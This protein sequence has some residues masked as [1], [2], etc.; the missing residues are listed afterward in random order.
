MIKNYQLNELEIKHGQYLKVIHQ[1]GTESSIG[2][3]LSFLKVF[4]DGQADEF[5]PP[6]NTVKE[7]KYEEHIIYA[8]IQGQ[9]YET[10]VWKFIVHE[11]D[12]DGMAATHVDGYLIEYYGGKGEEAWV[13][14]WDLGDN[15]DPD[16]WYNEHLRTEFG[17]G[18]LADEE[19]YENQSLVVITLRGIDGGGYKVDK[20]KGL[21]FDDDRRK[22]K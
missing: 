10:W 1:S 18:R 17:D 4:E 7:E 13:L 6:V 21:R 22:I 2:S 19:E 20:E 5:G 15:V 16:E 14:F 8:I 12:M 11:Y 3:F 9:D